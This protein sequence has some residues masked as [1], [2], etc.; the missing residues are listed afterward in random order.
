MQ[1]AR[2]PDLIPWP[3]QPKQAPR[4]SDVTAQFGMARPFLP[5][6]GGAW[7]E[8]KAEIALGA[9]MPAAA[10]HNRHAADDC[11]KKKSWQGGTRL[12]PV[13]WVER[14]CDSR[15]VSGYALDVWFLQFD[16]SLALRFGCEVWL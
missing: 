11:T 10:L 14:H 5:L 13:R 16:G 8:Q 4:N 9:G 12:S 1:S 7:I 3:P 6:C 2:R 15:Q